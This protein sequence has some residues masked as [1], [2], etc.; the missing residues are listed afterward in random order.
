MATG[1]TYEIFKGGPTGQIH[2]PGCSKRDSWNHGQG[3]V[4]QLGE[5]REHHPALGN[6]QRKPCHGCQHSCMDSREQP[7]PTC[8]YLETYILPY[9][10]FH[11]RYPT[12]KS[13]TCVSCYLVA[14]AIHLK[15]EIRLVSYIRAQFFPPR[16]WPIFLNRDM[17]PP[18]V[19]LCLSSTAG[20]G[21]K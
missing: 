7:L 11:S 17:Q 5:K 2:G 20:R 18:A 14:S 9:L 15:T 1:R 10:V 4:T 8:F 13:H 6:W 12:L 16:Y 19:G 21:L 3:E